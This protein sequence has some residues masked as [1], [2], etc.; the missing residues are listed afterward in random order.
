MSY[1]TNTIQKDEPFGGATILGK[2][3]NRIGPSSEAVKAAFLHSIDGL[4]FVEEKIA[5]SIGS[6]APILTEIASYLQG[7]GGK[8]I[9]PLLA[10]LCGRLFGLYPPSQQLIDAAAGIELIHMATL[11]HDDIIDGSPTRRHQ[12]SAFSKFGLTPSLL[13]GDFLLVKAFG[14][15]AKLDRFIIEAT[16]RACIELT[17]GEVL[18]GTI[19]SERRPNFEEYLNIVSKKT[20]SLFSLAGS[21][22]AHTAGAN[23]IQVGHLKEFGLSAGIAFQMIDDILDITADEDLLGKPSGTDLKQKTP[24]LVNIIW[25]E[26]G[27]LNAV[28][29]FEKEGVTIEDAKAQVDY[30]RGSPV[31]ERCR[32]LAKSYAGKA[33]EEL[34][35]VTHPKLDAEVR[36]QLTAIVEYTLNR[37]L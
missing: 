7:L 12:E 22:G 26:S 28:H 32:E 24:S 23:I 5:Q 3:A 25:L 15:C 10:V 21:V 37:C 2:D 6:D 19:T 18:E 9:R 20:A 36:A 1:Q 27:D 29:F 35:A 17:E 16:E 31:I 13:T 8:R 11:L 30:L 14:L 34:N 33:L 4:Q